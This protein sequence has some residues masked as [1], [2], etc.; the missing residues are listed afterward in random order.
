MWMTA[1]LFVGM[2]V[3]MTGGLF[4]AG[5]VV[6]SV[7]L[8]VA[9]AGRDKIHTPGGDFRL[10]KE[11][12]MGPRLLLYPRVSLELPS[13]NQV[14]E[15]LKEAQ[16]G[17][18]VVNYHSGD[19]RV[20][21]DDW[22]KSHLMQDFARF[23]ARDEPVPEI[24]KMPE[25][26]DYDVAYASNR[27]NKTGIVALAVDEAGTKIA[28]I[29]INKGSA[30]GRVVTAAAPVGASAAPSNAPTLAPGTRDTPSNATPS[31]QR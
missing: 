23:D 5:R 12:D 24:F 9:L 3:L 2:G 28:L 6:R 4:M 31:P 21:V 20:F 26:A 22:Y 27:G 7:G 14:A 15:S 1:G 10:E 29:R 13:T 16:Q 25:L 8:G 30:S 18:N 19:P 11:A 17:I